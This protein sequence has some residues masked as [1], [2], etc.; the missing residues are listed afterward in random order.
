VP[1][2]YADDNYYVWNGTEG[3]YQ[4]V[5]PPSQVMQQAGTAQDVTQLYAYPKNGQSVEQQA[6]DRQEC[7]N[8]AAAQTGLTAAPPAPSASSGAAN[9][10]TAAA[11]DPYASQS[12]TPEKREQYLR[13]EG[14]CLQGRGYSVD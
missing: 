10:G 7:Q 8:W 3:A 11:S 12:L 9:P 2:Y 5:D 4:A 6:Q 1:Y 14:A 13:A